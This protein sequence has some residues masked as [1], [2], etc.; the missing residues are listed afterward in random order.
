MQKTDCLKLVNWIKKTKKKARW[1]C[2]LDTFGSGKGQ[3]LVFV[4]MTVDS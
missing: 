2:G 3:V 1:K 4:H